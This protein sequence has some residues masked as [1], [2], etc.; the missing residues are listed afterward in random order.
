M[1]R[2]RLTALATARWCFEHKPVFSRG[3]ILRDAAINFTNV[4]VSFQDTSSLP[5]KKHWS[6]VFRL[7]AM[8]IF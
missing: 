3:L 4:A 1:K 7:I 5:Q 8:M 2:A 6:F